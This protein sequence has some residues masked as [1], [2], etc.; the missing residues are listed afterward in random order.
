MARVGACA[1]VIVAVT[2][3]ATAFISPGGMSREL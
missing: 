2:A 1:V 3:M